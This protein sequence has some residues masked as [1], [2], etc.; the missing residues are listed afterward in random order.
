MSNLRILQVLPALNVGGVE[1]ATLDMVAALRQISPDTYVASAGGL[2]IPELVRLGGTHL[3]LP[4]NSKNPL[5]LLQ[6]A[7]VLVQLIRKYN[8][9]VI[10]ARSRAPAWSALWAARWTE[11]PFVTTYHGTYL[12]T[13]SL[14]TFY[15][16]VMTRGDRVIAISEFIA[17][18]IAK[19]HPQHSSPIDLIREGIDTKVFDPQKVSK[20]DIAALKKAWDIPKNAIVFLLPGRISRIKGQTVFVEALRR[21]N[22]PHVVGVILGQNQGKSSYPEEVARLSQELP[23]RLIANTPVPRIAYAAADFVVYP[24]IEP[25]AFGRVTAEAGAMERVVIATDHGATP[26]LCKAGKTGFLISPHD[27]EALT[28]AMKK[29]LDLSSA[30]RHAMGKAARA[31]IVENFTLARMCAQTIDLYRELIP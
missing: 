11:T 16:S 23:I 27:S 14:K 7:Y 21:L 5:R 22:H 17:R 2:L 18:Y 28:I 25:E 6:N 30:Q 15:N 10:H 3:Y 26:E 13:N 8:I 20:D 4:A 9:Q 24:S 12:S 29:A 31:H 1:R 19:N